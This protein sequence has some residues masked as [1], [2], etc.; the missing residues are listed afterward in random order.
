MATAGYLRLPTVSLALL[1]G[2]PAPSG[3]DDLQ[4]GVIANYTIQVACA[5]EQLLAALAAHS[6]LP[7]LLS[8][9]ATSPCDLKAG[10][11]C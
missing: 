11:C 4:Q 5:N 2:A 3:T 10:C 7:D 9:V 8:V 1:Q 6:L